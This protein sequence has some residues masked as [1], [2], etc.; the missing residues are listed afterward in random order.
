MKSLSYKNQSIDLDNKSIDWFLY[1][2][3]IHHSATAGEIANNSL[4]KFKIEKL[5]SYQK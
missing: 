3:S 1:H 5:K 4:K 2:G